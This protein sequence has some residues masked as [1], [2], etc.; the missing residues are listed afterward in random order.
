MRSAKLIWNPAANTGRH[1]RF[2]PEAK[3]LLKSHGLDVDLQL[4]TRSG[5]A[6]D[7]AQ[8]AKEDGFELII[9]AGGDGT[10]HEIVNGIA[11][12]AHATTN[13]AFGPLGILPYGTSNELAFALKLPRDLPTLCQRMALG[14]ARR[15]DLFCVNGRTYNVASM[16]IG[17]H[18]QVGITARTM[19]WIAGDTRYLLAVFK[20]LWQHYRTPA[21]QISLDGE[22]WTQD[23][24]FITTALVSRIGGF[25]LTPQ[26][27]IDDGLFDVCMVRG[28]GRWQVVRDVPIFLK[29]AHGDKPYVRLAQGRKLMVTSAEPLAVDSDGEM[30]EGTDYHW[31]IEVEL[32]PQKLE[33]IA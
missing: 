21:V 8:R 28:L 4:T 17:F 16:G 23:I 9:S 19:R 33:V 22:T 26:A 27:Q 12:C 20:T 25:Y 14:Q 5:E 29:G 24:L 10:I 11:R 31:Q 30:L 15:V 32:L 2:A 13:G 18:P 3:A 1:G 6:T 7:L